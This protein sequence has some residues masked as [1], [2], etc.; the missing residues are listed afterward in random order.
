LIKERLFYTFLLALPDFSK[1][2]EI[3]CDTSGIG[4]EVVLMKEK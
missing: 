4:V 2:F 1:A 3:E